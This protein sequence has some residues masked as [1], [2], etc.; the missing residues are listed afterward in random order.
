[1]CGQL[2]EL[3]ELPPRAN[4]R[5]VLTAA[6][7][8]RIADGWQVDE[9]GPHCAHFFATRAGERIMSTIERDPVRPALGA[10]NS[11]L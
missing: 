5:A 7:E 1:M 11:R 10:G 4:Q 8:A 3:T 6:R 9:V 2:L